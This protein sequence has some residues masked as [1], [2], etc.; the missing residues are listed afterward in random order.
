MLTQTDVFE[1]PI[2]IFMQ[3]PSN[4]QIVHYFVIEVSHFHQAS[5]GEISFFSSQFL[6]TSIINFLTS[7]ALSF[8]GRPP[9]LRRFGSLFSFLNPFLRSLQKLS[10]DI[11]NLLCISCQDISLSL[12]AYN[13]YAFLSDEIVLLNTIINY[14]EFTSL[15]N[16][17]PIVSMSTDQTS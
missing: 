6:Q 1:S 8:L 11:C 5:R 16:R 15:I 12:L 4:S 17:M 3:C 2:I 13:K 9:R 10:F 7:L 14:E